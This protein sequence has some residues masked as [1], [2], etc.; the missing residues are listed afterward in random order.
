MFRVT[1]TMVIQCIWNDSP[2]WI[3]W[4]GVSTRGQYQILHDYSIME[5]TLRSKSQWWLSGTWSLK[6][7]VYWTILSVKNR[8]IC[9][10]DHCDHGV[11]KYLQYLMIL[12][13]HI[14]ECHRLFLLATVIFAAYGN[15]SKPVYYDYGDIIFTWI[16]TDLWYQ[17][18]KSGAMSKPSLPVI[19]VIIHVIQ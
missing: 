19:F 2:G 11:D 14:W 1:I 4:G 5:H 7:Q 15:L 8:L 18:I 13:R 16:W 3:P 10:H 17:H 6:Q 12:N 9:H